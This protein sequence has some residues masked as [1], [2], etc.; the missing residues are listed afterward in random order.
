MSL[1]EIIIL[2]IGSLI[3][4]GA[5]ILSIRVHFNN[6]N[7]D[8]LLEAEEKGHRDEKLDMVISIVQNID[9]KFEKQETKIE[10]I[11]VSHEKLCERVIVIEKTTETAFKKIDTIE[12]KVNRMA[13]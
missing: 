8:I 10:D 13:G 9:K 7:K 4:L 2:C 3:S 1:I 6:K 11:K 5:L 12:E